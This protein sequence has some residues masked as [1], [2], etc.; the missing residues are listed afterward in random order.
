MQPR[1]SVSKSCIPVLPELR[2]APCT[3]LKEVVAVIYVVRDSVHGPSEVCHIVDVA[4]RVHITAPP[5]MYWALIN[6]RELKI[7]QLATA[8]LLRYCM[9]AQRLQVEVRPT[10]KG[11]RH[12]ALE[13]AAMHG[14]F[15]AHMQATRSCFSPP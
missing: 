15:A 2:K 1:S 12:D 4:V 10:V 11:N 14:Q 7:W 9:P 5:H 8:V 6:P 3:H 13:Q